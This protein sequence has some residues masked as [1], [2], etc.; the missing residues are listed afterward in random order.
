[1][2]EKI[3]KQLE[4]KMKRFQYPKLVRTEQKRKEFAWEHGESFTL[5]ELKAKIGDNPRC[6]LTGEPIDLSKPNTYCFDHIIPRCRGGT[7]KLDNLGLSTIVA[8][9]CKYTMT[10]DEFIAICKQVIK[11]AE[12]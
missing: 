12:S 4:L 2:Q 1:M 9:Y 7:N 5:A 11:T 8:N 10:Y 6:Y 3:D